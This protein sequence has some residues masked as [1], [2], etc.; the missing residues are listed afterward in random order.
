MRRLYRSSRDK[1]LFG[2]C[3]G[4]AENVGVDAN[5]LRILLVILAVFSGGAVILVYLIAGFI[6]PRDPYYDGNPPFNGGWGGA[7]NQP[8]QYGTQ[9]WPP[10]NQHSGSYSAGATGTAPTSFSSASSSTPR[11]AQGLDAM[12]E[13]VEKKALRREIE[14]LRAKITK[15]ENQ[16]KGE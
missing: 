4:L 12:M 14:E 5:L 10:G 15:I 1:K 6:I 11:P 16:S 9:G 2:V 7:S 3:G 13:D 8:P